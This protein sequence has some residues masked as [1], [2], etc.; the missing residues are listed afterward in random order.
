[1]FG[2]SSLGG[3][4]LWRGTLPAKP[5]AAAQITPANDKGHAF[6]AYRKGSR[7][8]SKADYPK[9]IGAICFRCFKK[10]D[11]AEMSCVGIYILGVADERTIHRYS[12]LAS[13]AGSLQR[14]RLNISLPLP[15]Y[16]SKWRICTAATLRGTELSRSQVRRHETLAIFMKSRALRRHRGLVQLTKWLPKMRGVIGR[17]PA[18]H[19]S[20]V[21]LRWRLFL[22][23]LAAPIS[24]L[25][26]LGKS[27]CAELVPK[28]RSCRALFII[29]GSGDVGQVHPP[30]A[31]C[32]CGA[33]KGFA[34]VSLLLSATALRGG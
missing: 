15:T 4:R 27:D 3:V 24:S 26:F 30:T 20:G 34:T 19:H 9:S 14:K 13:D 23:D 31:P 21:K 18:I 25:R 12:F 5:A 16:F 28:H 29:R 1:M 17:T 6:G 33:G 2:S 22:I 8:H 32:P 10:E 7:Q 11:G